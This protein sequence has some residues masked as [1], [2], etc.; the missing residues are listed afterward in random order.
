MNTLDEQVNFGQ[1]F[2]Y[3][4]IQAHILYKYHSFIVFSC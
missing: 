4:S 3:N 1:K 2:K